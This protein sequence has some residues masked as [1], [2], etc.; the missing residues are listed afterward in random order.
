MQKVTVLYF[1]GSNLSLPATGGS[2]GAV[3]SWTGP[4]GFISAVQNPTRTSVTTAMAGTYS[5]T[6]TL[7]GCVS[8]PA[9]V[10]VVVNAT[11]PNSAIRGRKACRILERDMYLTLGFIGGPVQ[12]RFD[13]SNL[14]FDDQ[15]VNGAYSP[16]NPTRQSF[17]NSELMYV[18]GSVGLTFSSTL[19]EAVEYYLGTAYFHFNRPKVA[20]SKDN[21][22]TLNKKI[23]ASGGLAVPTGDFDKFIIYADYFSQGGSSQAQGGFMYKHDLIQQDEDETVSLTG[24]VFLRWND[25]VMPVIKLNYYKLGVGLTYDANI[26]KLRTASQS[27]G[28]FELTV[29]FK[30]F[31]NM[32]NSSANKMRCPVT[33]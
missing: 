28:G 10:N 9:T 33:F 1:T 15:F 7:N 4:G 3:Y 32:N 11:P 17:V 8:S 14:K 16:T 30:S 31:L 24:G 13:P 26:S 18:D 27:R 2:T 12:Q 19:G 22:I 6:V 20:F 25:A 23:V 29:S 5:V 21:D